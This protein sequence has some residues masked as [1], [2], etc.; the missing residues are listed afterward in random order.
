MKHLPMPCQELTS[1]Y[2][3]LLPSDFLFLTAWH[4]HLSQ[5]AEPNDVL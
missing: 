5:Q 3:F 1:Q 2:G 4:H